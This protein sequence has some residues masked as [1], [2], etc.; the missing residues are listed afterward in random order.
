M[1]LKE[2]CYCEGGSYCLVY[3]LIIAMD[4]LNGDPNYPSYKRA[5]GF[6]QPVED[7][8]KASGVGLSNG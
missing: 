7:L 4:R 2:Y 6:K 8:L 5:Y 1:Q 3:A